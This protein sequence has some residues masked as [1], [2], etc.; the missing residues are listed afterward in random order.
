MLRRLALA[1]MVALLVGSAPLAQT[2]EPAQDDS[3]EA[4]RTRANAGDA[5]AQFNL[6]VMYRTGEGVPQD[7]VEAVAWTR[8]AAEQGHA[9][10]QYNLG[11]MYSYGEGVPQDDVEAV[12]WYRQAAEQ[13]Y[14]DAQYNLGVA[15]A[16]GEGVP[17]DDVE[18][19]K[20]LILATTYADAEQREEFAEARDLTAE[21]LTPE[22]RAEG[23]KLAREWFA[24]HPR[25]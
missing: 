7:A 14:A 6:G 3:I 24:A 25:D 21:P 13:G 17:Q 1:G 19:Y 23:Q 18:A 15:Y 4:L 2:P 10:A 16:T 20:W 9:G 22:Q 8:Q 5:D 12:A 11:V